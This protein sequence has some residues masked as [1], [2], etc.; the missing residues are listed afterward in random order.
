M[1]FALFAVGRV[2]VLVF[3]ICL[4]GLVGFCFLAMVAFALFDFGCV[5]VLVLDFV[6]SP[7]L[8]CL[9]LLCPFV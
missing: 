3:G 6:C 7:L 1:A 2:G 4:F 5:G 8:G 9:V